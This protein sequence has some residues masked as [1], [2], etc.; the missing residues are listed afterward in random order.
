M[1]CTL[2]RRTFAAGAVLAA[3]LPCPY[4]ARADEPLHLRCSLDT[5]PSHKRN[6]SI[7]D[8]LAKLEKASGG[9]IRTEL[10]QS[11]QLFADLN[12]GRALIQGQ[13]E[14]AAPGSWVLTGLIPDAD[15]FNL[16]A[17]YGQPIEVVHRA[18][19]GPT[20]ALL[21]AEIE[22]RLRS[23]VLG[24][25]LDLG[26]DNWYSA[27]KPL[28]SLADLQ[29]MKI[30]NPGG[31]GL[32]WR[33]RFFGAIANTTA[34]PNVPLALS[35]GTFDGLISTDESV[36]S[37]KLWEAGVKYSLAD[38]QFVGEYIPMISL[39]FWNKLGP[40]LQKLITDLWAENIPTYRANMAAAQRE[41]RQVL[42]AHGVQFTDPPAQE[43]AEA[44]GRMLAHQ[45]EVAKLLNI[46]PQMVR[47]VMQDIGAVRAG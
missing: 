8:F 12:V 28:H 16:P 37:A 23:R 21:A 38:H 13:V 1:T 9:R 11:G 19:D 17:L 3:A 47:Q 31:A 36:A 41:A 2:S 29:G 22:K 32:S 10:F 6:G 7:A 44:R 33:T 45:D 15:F 14:M 4:V 46:S 27:T 35:Q 18:I 30:R 42:A 34:W 5:A 20:G 39:V 43:I 24:P 25:W 26:Y 40:E